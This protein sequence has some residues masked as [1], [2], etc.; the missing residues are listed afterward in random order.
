[1]N[2]RKHKPLPKE[3]KDWLYVDLSIPQGLRWRKNK[4]RKKQGDPAGCRF[5]AGNC[6]YYITR[7]NG[8]TYLNHRVIYF[9]Q[10]NQDPGDNLIDHICHD[11]RN[12]AIRLATQQQNVCYRAKS[13]KSKNKYKGVSYHKRDKLWAARITANGKTILLGYFKKET[14]AAIAYNRAA[15]K[16]FKEFAYINLIDEHEISG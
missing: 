2:N 4:A 11:K 8:V 15:L 9:L 5:T 1:M 7:F 14:D 6:E 13:T 3:L 16:Y 10:T 12:S